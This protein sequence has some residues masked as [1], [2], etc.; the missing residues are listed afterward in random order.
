[1]WVGQAYG[2]ESSVVM[3][4]CW[5]T[6][7]FDFKISDDSGLEFEEGEGLMDSIWREGEPAK[8]SVLQM[9]PVMPTSLVEAARPIPSYALGPE[10]WLRRCCF[11][12]AAW[13]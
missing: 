13:T 6:D 1:M 7:R 3:A 8:V 11:R 2:D 4:K 5:P 9:L 12:L 10:G